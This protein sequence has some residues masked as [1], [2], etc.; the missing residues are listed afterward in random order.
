MPL[1]EDSDVSYCIVW[2]VDIF[3]MSVY[4]TQAIMVKRSEKQVCEQ[5]FTKHALSGSKYNYLCLELKPVQDRGK[6]CL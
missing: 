6:R 4:D 5:S 3:N 2:H 1:C